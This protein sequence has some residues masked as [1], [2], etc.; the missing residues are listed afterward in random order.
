MKATLTA[1]LLWT[2]AVGTRPATEVQQYLPLSLFITL[3]AGTSNVAKMQLFEL[4]SYL[5]KVHLRLNPSPKLQSTPESMGKYHILPFLVTLSFDKLCRPHA[6]EHGSRGQ[7]ESHL[8]SGTFSSHW[9]TWGAL[10][11]R[12]SLSLPV[13][14]AHGCLSSEGVRALKQKAK[15]P[16]VSSLRSPRQSDPNAPGTKSRAG[17]RERS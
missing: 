10:A 11:A 6:L 13:P 2:W 8:V 4:K 12:E 16:C 3:P 7:K 17:R 5:Q 1:T 14:T 15:S 9:S